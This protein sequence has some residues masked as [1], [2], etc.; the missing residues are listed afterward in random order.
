MN[1]WNSNLIISIE[2]NRKQWM[3]LLTTLNIIF[4][5]I[6]KKA[7]ILIFKKEIY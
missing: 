6:H 2:I 3:V 5:V 4:S 7:E 1:Y